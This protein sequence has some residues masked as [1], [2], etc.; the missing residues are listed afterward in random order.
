MS[1]NTVEY[2]T[3]TG[4]NGGNLT[5]STDFNQRFGQNNTWLGCW[6]ENADG[7]RCQGSG[8]KYISCKS[9]SSTA[10]DVAVGDH[11]PPPALAGNPRA[12][13]CKFT[14]CEFTVR[15][16]GMSWAGNLPARD[17]RIENHQ[18][19]VNLVSGNHTGTVQTGDMTETPVTPIKMLPAQVGPNGT[20][21]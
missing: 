12:D 5:Y 21:L 6:S 15:V 18:G 9:V 2:C 3:I 11:D 13:K 4:K 17:T 7:Y 10:A 8:H 16:G 20:G 19:S 1:G 14:A